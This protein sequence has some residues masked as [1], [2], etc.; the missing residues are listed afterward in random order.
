MSIE[1]LRE[2]RKQ[3]KDRG[4]APNEKLGEA[5]LDLMMDIRRRKNAAVVA[6]IAKAEKP[7]LDEL[8]EVED[9]YAIFLK[10]AS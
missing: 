7:F 4:I 9:D 8:Q 10:L 6:A 2:A 3:I 1:T 5:Y